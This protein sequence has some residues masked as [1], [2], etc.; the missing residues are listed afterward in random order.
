MRPDQE[1][2][3][4]A[5]YVK[6]SPN[7]YNLVRRY[8]GLRLMP[9]MDMVGIWTV[10]Y[11][12]TTE[13]VPGERISQAEAEDRLQEDMEVAERCVNDAVK[14]PLTQNQ[15]DALCSWVYNLGC[16][17]FRQSTMLMR[18]NEQKWQDAS[19]EL[20]KWDMAGGKHVDGLMRR[21]RDECKLFECK[22]G[23]IAA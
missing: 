4:G 23:S 7:A 15:F 20:R 11:G 16:K 12:S 6:A 18:I 19:I 2:S 14:V 9:Y 1:G 22:D 10:G 8:E 5:G 21:R 3:A 17:R 13:V